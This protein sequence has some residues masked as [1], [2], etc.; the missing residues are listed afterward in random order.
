[1]TCILKNSTRLF[2]ILS[3]ALNGMAAFADS[4]CTQ[5]SSTDNPPLPL[6]SNI[7]PI[8]FGTSPYPN[9]PVNQPLVSV[10]ICV[11]GTGHC[12]TID[13]LLLDT[14]SHGLRIF[15]SLIT[16]PLPPVNDPVNVGAG[17]TESECVGYLAGAQQWG[18]VVRA[19][20]IMGGETANNVNMQEIDA[21]YPSGIPP[22]SDCATKAVAFPSDSSYNGVVGVGFLAND[23]GT[24]CTSSRATNYYKCSGNSPCVPTAV[25]PSYQVQNLISKMNEGFNNGVSITLPPIGYCGRSGLTG[26]LTLGV[27][28]RQNNTP[29]VTTNVLSADPIDLTIRTTFE[30][31]QYTGYIDSGTNTFNFSPIGRAAAE[32]TD[33]GSTSE[34]PGFF[35]PTDNPKYSAT[36]QSYWGGPLV[37]V[38]FQIV[39][40]LSLIGS[41][42]TAFSTLGSGGGTVGDFDWG[43][44]FFFGK[45]VYVVQKDKSAP[46]LGVGPIWAF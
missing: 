21:S 44:S 20:V 25:R 34:A 13:H 38:T 45:T 18:A 41:N 8:S 9:P 26:Y 15:K 39:N 27:G 32:L 30:G 5:I 19:D 17:Y 4:G 3:I 36:M 28:T 40:A 2:L 43:I 33:C 35:C 11:P 29:P 31:Q 23:C 14:G 6:G 42:N 24:G 12:L 1:M 16:I 22:G 46:G 10:T 37:P 7:I